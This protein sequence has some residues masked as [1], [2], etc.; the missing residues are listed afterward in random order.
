MVGEVIDATITLYEAVNGKSVPIS[1]AH[2]VMDSFS[3]Y[4]SVGAVHFTGVPV[5]TWVTVICKKEGFK[6]LIVETRTYRENPFWTWHMTRVAVLPPEEEAPPLALWKVLS[7][8][9]A[10][11]GGSAGV[12]YLTKE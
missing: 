4:T 10:I 6:D 2:V 5:D 8:I 3:G 12:Y 11:I 9:F 7:I 1:D